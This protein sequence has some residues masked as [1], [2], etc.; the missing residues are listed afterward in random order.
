LKASE[1]AAGYALSAYWRLNR[2]LPKYRIP[3]LRPEARFKTTKDA[4]DTPPAISGIRLNADQ[5]RQRGL[6]QE[7]PRELRRAL[8]PQSARTRQ[9]KSGSDPVSAQKKEEA[10]HGQQI[11]TQEGCGGRFRCYDQEFL[12][13]I[14]PIQ[15]PG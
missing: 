15:I 13:S 5:L 9:S 4:L 10:H 14:F 7:N 6:P 3:A 8:V 12:G 1:Y 2:M 11:N